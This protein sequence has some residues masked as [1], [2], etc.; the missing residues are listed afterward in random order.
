MD[1]RTRISAVALSG[2]L[3]VT[4]PGQDTGKD[5]GGLHRTAIGATVE[6]EPPWIFRGCMIKAN[7]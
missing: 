1:G 6:P 5:S 7:S 2:H 3:G 4:K